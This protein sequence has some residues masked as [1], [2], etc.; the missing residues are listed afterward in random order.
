MTS[1]SLATRTGRAAATSGDLVCGLASPVPP[2]PFVGELG[3]PAAEA[4]NAIV[5]RLMRAAGHAPPVS[6]MVRIDGT[7]L[8]TLA[9]R[10]APLGGNAAAPGLEGAGTATTMVGSLFARI[11]GRAVARQGD[12]SQMSPSSAMAIVGGR[13]SIVTIGGASVPEVPGLDGPG[14]ALSAIPPRTAFAEPSAAHRMLSRCSPARWSDLVPREHAVLVGD[15][16]DVA[17]G[18]VVTEALDFA[19]I[20]PRV[21]FRRHYASNRCDRDGPLGFGWGHSYDCAIWL[22]PGRVVLREDDGREVE[23]DALALPGGV[24][25]AGDVLCDPAG[26]LQLFCRGR[27]RW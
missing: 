27:F 22:E 8:A 12:P 24:A 2:Q 20:A 23:F 11:G 19:A 9:M 14:G 1:V 10:A 5:D 7:L 15:P 3:D 13:Q 26:R 17:T 25:R 6:P 16:V 18:A 4:A 21:E